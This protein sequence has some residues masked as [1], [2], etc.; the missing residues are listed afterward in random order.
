M[1]VG[2]MNRYKQLNKEAL[3]WQNKKRIG[4]LLRSSAT[5]A[6]WVWDEHAGQGLSSCSV[7]HVVWFK[8][9]P[10]ADR[11]PWQPIQPMQERVRPTGL[12]AT[13]EFVGQRKKDGRA[14]KAKCVTCNRQ[15]SG[16]LLS[17]SLCPSSLLRWWTSDLPSAARGGTAWM[18]GTYSEA[19]RGHAAVD[20]LTHAQSFA[21]KEWRHLAVHG[22]NC[23]FSQEK[24]NY[25]SVY[26]LEYSSN[27][28]DDEIHSPEIKPMYIYLCMMKRSQSN[29][30]CFDGVF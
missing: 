15:A 9:K 20:T 18:V 6:V 1:Y 22:Q 11:T 25:Y 24:P 21:H 19:D 30:R 17:P 28:H 10:A 7:N 13:S 2:Y 4:V 3:D 27:S 5:L 23:F 29:C 12:F 8:V 16:A 14:L 26:L